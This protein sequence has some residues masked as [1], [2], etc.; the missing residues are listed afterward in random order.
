M[1]AGIIDGN[2]D[3]ISAAGKAGITD[4]SIIT[5][6]KNATDAYIALG[7]VFKGLSKQQRINAA[8]ALGLD[9]ASIRLLSQGSDDGRK[10]V[11][12]EK[13]MRPF[14]EEMTKTAADFND[15]MQ[16]LFSNTGGFADQ[17]SV[18]LLPKINEIIGATNN[19]VDAN[20]GLINQDMGAVLDPIAK[21]FGTLATAGGL[22]ASGGL[23]AGLAGMAKYVPIIGK[24]IA[25]A[26]TSAARLSTIG[27]GITIGAKLW[28]WDAKDLKEN[29]GIDAPDWLFK[30]IDKLGKQDKKSPEKLP[31]VSSFPDLPTFD[32]PKKSDFP[33]LPT[34]GSI[35]N[36]TSNSTHSEITVNMMLDGQV[37]DRRIVNVV[38]GQAELAYQNIR[39][40]VVS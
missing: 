7:D 32:A 11:S 28:N 40:T 34:F 20:R 17:I 24:G 36:G 1:R 31:D 4:T 29:L 16:N 2:A 39:S 8:G 10:A 38:N 14:T 33:D 3:W 35:N 9:D 26:A 23:L 27:A 21:N 25:I 13:Q 30:P 19:W 12:A 6:A 37:M 22:L 5:N 15:Q 18:K